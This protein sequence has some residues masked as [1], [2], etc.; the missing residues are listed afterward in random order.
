MILFS[1]IL[2]PLPGMGVEFTIEEKTGP[3]IKPIRTYEQVKQMHLMDPM[4]TCPFVHQTLQDLRREVGNEATVLGFVG[5]PYT[6]ATYLVEGQSSKE[7]LEIKKMMFQVRPPTHLPPHPP[8][9]PQHLIPTAS[10]SSIH[11]PTHPPTSSHRNPSFSTKCSLSWR[12]TLGTTPISRLSRALRSFRSLIHG[13]G[14]YHHLC[15]HAFIHP[16]TYPF[17][18]RSKSSRPYLLLSHPPNQPTRHLSPIDYDTFAAPYQRQVIS[19][20]KAKNPTVPIIIY[21]N[22]SGA[23]LER[24]AQT[25][26]DIVSLDWTVTMEEGRRRLGGEMG[27]QGRWVGGWVVE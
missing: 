25:G 20:I 14:K 7:Y 13:P 16:L 11:P 2:T 26:V 1:D 23:L 22:K 8:S 4:A 5:L 18:S 12:T 15:R 21:I 17:I 19:K 24:M 10:F 9:N 6:L 3:K 27:V